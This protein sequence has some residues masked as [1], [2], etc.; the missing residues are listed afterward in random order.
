MELVSSVRDLVAEAARFHQLNKGSASERSAYQSLVRNGH[1]FFVSSAEKTLVFAPSRYVGYKANTPRRHVQNARK[2]GSVTDRR[3]RSVVGRAPRASFKLDEAYRSFCAAIGVE[4]LVHRT[5]KFWILDDL[6]E[7]VSADVVDI[8]APNLARRTS[9]QRFVDTRLGQGQF[10]E[11]VLTL[12]NGKCAVTECAHE[13]LLKASHIKS[14]AA[15]TNKERLDPS[16]GLALCANA[17]ALFDRHLISFDDGGKMLIS[18]SLS[19]ELIAQ[20]GLSRVRP[21][22]LS[23]ASRRYMGFHRQV[24]E[25]KRRAV[26]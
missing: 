6:L 21:L 7:N 11:Q 13:A 22:P 23:A 8:L 17:D 4:N 5:R 19:V 1:N 26:I 24:F 15:S 14:W 2:H 20:L 12:W 18:D 10:R 9:V 25:G 16:N 3:I